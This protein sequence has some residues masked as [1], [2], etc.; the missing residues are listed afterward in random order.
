MSP[1]FKEKK[2]IKIKKIYVDV[3]CNNCLILTEIRYI[4]LI[5]KRSKVRIFES[6]RKMKMR[7]LQLHYVHWVYNIKLSYTIRFFL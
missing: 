6:E 1:I 4:K 7:E 2:I 5:L 3:A